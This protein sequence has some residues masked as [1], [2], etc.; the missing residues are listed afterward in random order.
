VSA[1]CPQHPNI[2]A[3]KD[4]VKMVSMRV[5]RCHNYRAPEGRSP[6]RWPVS[7]RRVAAFA[8]I[9]ALCAGNL[10]L[11]ACSATGGHTDPPPNPAAEHHTYT[12]SFPLTEGPISEGDKWMNGKTDGL[13]WS[14]VKT[15]P[16]LAFG[17][18]VP[19]TG[20]PYN[21]S[22]AILKGSWNADQMATATVHTV[23]QQ[24]GS[25]YEEVELWLRGSISPHFTT[26]YEINLRCLTGSG[27]Y[28]QFG[29]WS[30]PLN[31][32]GGLGATTG[33]GLRD[34]DV[35]SARIVG[36]TITIW[37]NGIQVLQGTDPQNRY[38]TGNPGMGFYYQ[39]STGSDSDYGFSSFTA[40]DNLQGSP[41]APSEVSFTAR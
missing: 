32:F 34:G 26:G 24:G 25:T 23:N 17:T 9:L 3:K 7:G 29:Y 20:P 18:Q 39:G 19:P 16:G 37:I 15:T 5:R 2:A 27:T 12:T 40:T 22:V 21:D 6:V 4:E 41:A 35:I 31:Q 1:G 38:K 8:L 36:N 28:V 30:G 13:D 14:D 10:L 33:P 11:I